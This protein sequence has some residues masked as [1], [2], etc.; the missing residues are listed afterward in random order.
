M[1]GIFLCIDK[2][3]N[4]SKCIKCLNILKNRGPDFIHYDIIDNMFL[5]QT[6]LSI[7]K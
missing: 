4:I 7:I 5:G 2:N 1:C 6:I 3:I